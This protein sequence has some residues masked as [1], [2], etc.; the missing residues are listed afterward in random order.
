MK[1]IFNF[2]NFFIG[3]VED[4]HD[5]LKLGRC[6]VRIFGYHSESKE[7]QPT[8]DLP[9]C[10]PISPITSASISGIGISPL[11]PI[12]GTWVI[13]FFLDGD[14]MQQPAMFGTI[15][16]N[17]LVSFEPVAE[18]PIVENKDTTVIKDKE[19]NPIP[20]SDGKRI[21]IG[22]TKSPSGWFLGKTSEVYESGGKGPGTLSPRTSNDYGGES[23]GVYQFASFLPKVMKNGNTRPSPNNS[24]L[25][26][27]VNNCRWK[28]RFAGLQ[29]ATDQFDSVWKQIAAESNNPDKTKDL[30]WQDQ[31]DYIKRKYY[32]TCIANVQRAGIDL[33]KFGP[34]VQDLVWSTSVQLGPA[35]TRVFTDPLRG[36]PQLSDV[37]IVKLVS[38]HKI[39]NV[40]SYFKSSSEAVR[41]SVKNRWEKEEQD[42]LA[43][44]KDSIN[45]S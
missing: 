34:A 33:S 8:K 36:K 27:Y 31:H 22:N 11:G 7:L 26:Q 44:A 43:L 32:N 30:F 37:E 45:A 12:E 42:L 2:T 38:Q 5:P 17:N 39:A 19:G 10:L 16:S 14:D 29:P 21:T 40:N 25:V 4:R 28:E 23:Y 15:A 18:R 41:R 35:N 6:K 3:V 13:G 24:P 1:K 20:D 9:W